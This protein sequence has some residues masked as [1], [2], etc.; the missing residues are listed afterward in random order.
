M[1]TI[2]TSHPGAIAYKLLMPFHPCLPIAYKL[3]SAVLLLSVSSLRAAEPFPGD[4]VRQPQEWWTHQGE[5]R[6][7][8]TVSA[9]RYD[10][11][12]WLEDL[13]PAQQADPL[14]ADSPE[15][16]VI[17]HVNAQVTLDVDMAVGLHV[18]YDWGAR[19]LFLV[20]FVDGDE[21]ATW[22][23]PVR[24]GDAGWIVDESLEFESPLFQAALAHPFSIDDSRADFPAASTALLSRV[25]LYGELPNDPI[26]VHVR[27]ATD[28]MIRPA[29]AVLPAAPYLDRIFSLAETGDPDLYLQGYTEQFSPGLFDLFRAAPAQLTAAMRFSQRIPDLTWVTDLDLG[30]TVISVLA[31]DANLLEVNRYAL[32]FV[33]TAVGEVWSLTPRIVE[34][35][36]ETEVREAVNDLLLGQAFLNGVARFAIARQ[37]PALTFAEAEFRLN[38]RAA[39]EPVAYSLSWPLDDP[40]SVTWQIIDSNLIELA[41]G[42]TAIAAGDTAGVIEVP[43]TGF[44]AASHILEAT[45]RFQNPSAAVRAG[46]HPTAR[47]RFFTADPVI[48]FEQPT[49]TVARTQTVAQVPLRLSSVY[50]N[51]VSA[52]LVIQP[53]G[54]ATAAEDYLIISPTVVFTAGQTRA[55]LEI[56]ILPGDVAQDADLFLQLRI[57]DWTGGATADPEDIFTLVLRRPEFRPAVQF[58]AAVGINTHTNDWFDV[59]VQLAAALPD[60]VIV[61]FAI[62]AATDAVAVEDFILEDGA[63]LIPAGATQAAIRVELPPQPGLRDAMR[64]LVIE[65]SEPS[66]NA[67]LGERHRFVLMIP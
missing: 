56:D 8:V 40:F 23:F 36:P 59:V 64:R 38:R 9:Y 46:A 26:D 37:T 7:A 22:P 34:A 28:L 63:L 57:D 30:N 44:R 19:R 20:R 67:A 32:P 55:D 31:D 5:T 17:A 45:I 14:Y 54:T 51:E 66:A 29:S 24:L 35:A 2:L 50:T 60:P 41:A 49:L 18:R 21:T 47:T 6:V 27:M 65:L 1:K 25:R 42:V 13:T 12:P 16:A 48:R 58:A 4:L 33:R 53:F 61:P 43:M 3:L 52:D 11:H 10:G 39:W 15:A 62:A